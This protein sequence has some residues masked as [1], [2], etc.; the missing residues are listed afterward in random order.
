M[1]YQGHF[2]ITKKDNID[3]NLL[4]MRRKLVATSLVV[5]VI[6]GGAVGLVRYSQGTQLAAS[7]LEAL[8]TGVC[9][10]VLLTAINLIFMLL[11]ING[12]YKSKQLTDFSFDVV[13][14][15][16]GE[17]VETVG[18]EGE[19]DGG[20]SRPRALA[21]D[22]GGNLLVLDEDLARVTKYGPD[23]AFVLRF[24]EKGSEDGQLDSPEGLA[25]DTMD[26]VYVADSGNG[27]I[28]VF[29]SD[30][31]FLGRIGARGSEDGEFEEGPFS[32]WVDPQGTVYVPDT[33]RHGVQLFREAVETPDDDTN[34]TA[35]DD[36][37]AVNLTEVNGTVANATATLSP[38]PT[39]TAVNI[40]PYATPT[41]PRSVPVPIAGIFAALAGVAALA[42]R[43]RT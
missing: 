1:Q 37:S 19:E 30:G 25:V 10:V 15:K 3:F 7:I 8:L 6:I 32:V 31:E 33:A 36:G 24:G 5:F 22:S 20:L 9:G 13:V 42:A 35:G 21:L 16:D 34:E 41:P 18:F 2:T 17:V 23:G 11:R 43:R 14:D 12:L 4:L 39:V 28:A 26:N 38:T 27:R 29:D 40:T